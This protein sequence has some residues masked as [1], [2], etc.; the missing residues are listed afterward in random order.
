MHKLQTI[1]RCN[2]QKLVNIYAV[3]KTNTTKSERRE[4]PMNMLGENTILSSR[5]Y[6]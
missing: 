4:G 1:Q 3:T 2:K 5:Y 6:V